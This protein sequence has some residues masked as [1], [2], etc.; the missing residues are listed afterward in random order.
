MFRSSLRKAHAAQFISKDEFLEA[1]Y[2]V[3]PLVPQAPKYGKK[4]SIDL[5]QSYV[6]KNILNWRITGLAISGGVDSMA[7]AVMCKE[8]T[9]DSDSR[10][11][12]FIVDHKL[13]ESSTRE[14]S[15][16]RSTLFEALGNKTLINNNSREP[17]I[18]I[19]TKAFL[20]RFWHFQSTSL[21]WQIRILKQRFEN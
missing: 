8:Y 13:R 11:Q 17:N 20:L 19:Y 6:I 1:L 21:R 5:G 3:W 2:R 7:L 15:T 10:V 12:A 18:L 9:P 4:V 14:A 16:I